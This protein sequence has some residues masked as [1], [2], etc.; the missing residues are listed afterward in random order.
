M[1]PH[2]F[3]KYI[4]LDRLAA[5]GMAEVYRGKLTGE[6]GFEKL[7]VIKR[8]LPQVAAKAEMVTAFIDE[9]RLAALLQHENI[10]HVYDFGE[11]DDAYF[12]AMEYLFGQELRSVLDK[13]DAS[14][15]PLSLAD[16]LTIAA[17]IC[18]GLHYAHELKDLKQRPLNIIHRDI[19]PQN[20]FVTYDG[21]IKII[22][23]GIAKTTVQSAHTRTGLVKGKIAYMSPEQ[24]K[25][26]PLD[27][28]SDIFAAGILLYEMVT[29]RR[30]YQGTDTLKVISKVIAADYPPPE[31]I[32]PDLPEMVGGIIRKALAK[33]LSHRYAT[34]W[35]MLTDIE[36][37]LFSLSLRGSAQSLSLLARSLFANEHAAEAKEIQRVM[38][39][40][41]PAADERS[42]TVVAPLPIDSGGT[43]TAA[44]PPLAGSDRTAT[45]VAAGGD[46]TAT[47]AA[48]LDRPPEAPGSDRK[49][50]L[51]TL[52]AAIGRRMAP[53]A[54][55]K[56][57]IL[58]VGGGIIALLAGCLLWVAI[59][60]PPADRP[61]RAETAPSA[62][63]AA[64][65]RP[66]DAAKVRPAAARKKTRTSSVSQSKE[67]P[68][69]ATADDT[70]LDRVLAKRGVEEGGGAGGTP[71]AE[72]PAPST[73]KAAGQPPQG[74]RSKSPSGSSGQVVASLLA[75]AEEQLRQLRLTT[76]ENDCA[77]YYYQQ[78]LLLEADN[79]A[80]ADGIKRIGD[81]Y[82]QL[83]DRAID[84]FKYDLAEEYVARGLEV[85]PEHPRL[86]VL[87]QKLGRDRPA[88]LLEDI[89]DK[90]KGWLPD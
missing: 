62:E 45:Q 47:V 59:S 13:A 11:L 22:D 64:E 35:Q 60:G 37:C 73:G 52:R 1:Q 4:L 28:R 82:G 23:F 38:S 68:E 3:G 16:S 86:L 14:G 15:H 90:V 88:V 72:A 78:V 31:A 7:V 77:L 26:S 54:W 8:M 56:G 27:R 81:K 9:A 71:T 19:S 25:G 69:E 44:V 33:D 18:D 50:R 61:E 76:P 74:S 53:D 42:S 29:G 84:Q 46:H 17:R 63:T 83:A 34:A 87:D 66:A 89:R 57:Q 70:F 48:A 67:A 30:M 65:P 32:V 2:R 20:I 43:A 79:A 5:G 12:I 10:V 80:A 55:S 85:V 21:K 6:Q 58:A 24:A 39:L 41:E 49:K 36:E 40:D 51:E 75:E